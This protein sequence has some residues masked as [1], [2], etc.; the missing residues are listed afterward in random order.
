MKKIIIDL[1]DTISFTKNGDYQNSVPDLEIIQ[2]MH[3]YSALGF[4]FTINTARQ[5]RTYEGNV[6]K[7]NKNTLPIILEWLKQHNVPYDEILV[8]KPWCGFEGFYVDDKSIRPSEFK[9]LSPEE[10]KELINAK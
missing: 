6:G 1:D 3:E 5:M 10:I 7:I 9:K 2:K 4:S 8:G